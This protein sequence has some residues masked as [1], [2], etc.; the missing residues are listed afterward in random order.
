MF[1][2]RCVGLSF[3]SCIMA[4]L[5]SLAIRKFLSS[6]CFDL[7]PFMLNWSILIVCKVVFLV[8]FCVCGLVGEVFVFAGGLVAWG[9]G[10]VSMSP[11]SVLVMRVWVELSYR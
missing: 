2:V 8:G 4:I 1:G 7:I 10:F 6:M 11:D 9:P 3:V 5:I